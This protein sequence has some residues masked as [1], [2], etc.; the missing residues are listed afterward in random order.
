MSG[1]MKFIIFGCILAV[2]P[3]ATILII[4][5]SETKYQDCSDLFRENEQLKKDIKFL[6]TEYR[7]EKDNFGFFRS[8]MWNQI[9][10]HNARC[11][12]GKIGLISN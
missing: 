11:T 2:V 10:L 9:D 4:A 5:N 8:H 3:T 6:K 12:H 7:K 1:Q